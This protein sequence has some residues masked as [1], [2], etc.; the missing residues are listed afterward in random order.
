RTSAGG[1]VGSL[2]DTVS[3]SRH[4]GSSARDFAARTQWASASLAYA[5]EAPAIPQ[6]GVTITDS[7]SSAGDSPILRHSDLTPL[8]LPAGSDNPPSGGPA[9]GTTPAKSTVPASTASPIASS[10]LSVSSPASKETP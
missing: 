10:S 8:T 7:A 9:A 6:A 3:S 5:G 4:S 2:R 1:V